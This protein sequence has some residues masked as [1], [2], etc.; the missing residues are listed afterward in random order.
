M[1]IENLD[2]KCYLDAVQNHW[3]R[4]KDWLKKGYAPDKF[5][6][7]DFCLFEKDGIFHLFHI[8]GTF[9]VSC[10]LPGNEIWFGHA[11]TRNFQHWVTY[12]P[13]FYINPRRWD[14]GHI[15]APFVIE[16]DDYYWMFYTGCK[17]DNTQRI[18]VAKSKDLFNWKRVGNKPVIRPEEYGWAFCPTTGG[19]ACRD[20]HVC[21]FDDKYS[22]YYTAVTREGK[23]CVARAASKDLIHWEDKG[24]AYIYKDLTHCESSNVQELNGQYLLFFGGHIEYWSY[25]IS[26]NPYHW[27]D[28]EPIPL[29]RKITAMEVVCRKDQ[30]WLVAFFK[31][32]S[33][34]LYLGTIDW[35]NGEPQIEQI[36][37]KQQLKIY[38]L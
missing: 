18:G 4:Q 29:G 27:N 12:G 5:Y 24:P 16:K 8:A 13:C 19:S 9:G 6:L 2:Y 30:L 37:E 34:R 36:S 26:D 25:V 15:F 20:P 35:S 22:L 38:G 10:C 33:F 11:S 14:G 1:P 3:V 31:F 32:N 17:I 21:K 7:K 23:A 28:Q